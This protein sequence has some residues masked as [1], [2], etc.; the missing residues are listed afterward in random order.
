MHIAGTNNVSAD[1]I[2]RFQM[3]HFR[4]LAPDANPEPNH[5][6]VLP[7]QLQNQCQSLGVAPST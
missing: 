7:N 6:R 5:I 1:A 4:S 3:Q 2:S